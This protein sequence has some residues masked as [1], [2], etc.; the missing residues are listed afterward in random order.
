MIETLEAEGKDR[1]GFL[2]LFAEATGKW[3]RELKDATQTE[4]IAGRLL[5]LA[6]QY[7]EALHRAALLRQLGAAAAQKLEYPR[8][9]RQTEEAA[10]IFRENKELA[11]LIAC[12]N[13]LGKVYANLGDY[14]RAID[15]FDESLSLSSD[16]MDRTGEA[17]TLSALS[18]IYQRA[19]NAVKAGELARKSLAIAA[20]DGLERLE[21]IS[22]INLGNSYALAE[23]WNNAIAEW[24]QSIS[25]F[26]KLGETPYV[27]SALGNIGIAYQG[28]GKL[29]EAKEN[30]ERCLAV[31]QELNDIYDIARSLHN[32]GTVYLKM[33]DLQEA[34]KL[35]D[36]ALGMGEASQAKAIHVLIYQDMAE[37]LK[38]MGDYKGALE[39][40]EKF[41]E[42]Q[43]SL[44]HE[45]ANIKT[46][47]LQIRFEVEKK[48]KEN[49]IYRLRNIDLASANEKITLQKE[50][51]EQK[52]KDITDSILY[53]KR[54]Q[55][56]VLPSQERLRGWFGELFTLYAPKDIV[57]GDFYWAAEKDGKFLLAVADATGHGVPGAIMSMMGS[58]FLSEIVGEQG[59]TEPAP[60]LAMLRRKVINAMQ[61]TDAE[62]GDGMDIVLCAFDAAK[63]ELSAACAN[64]PLWL[65]RDENIT[66]VAPDKFP[67]GIFPGEPRRFTAHAV[68]LQ[69]GD[70]IYM[71]TDGFADQ[72]G[73]PRGKKFSYKQLRELLL[74]IHKLP[75]ETQKAELEKAF[76]EWKGKDEEQVDDVLVVGIRI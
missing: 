40:F 73:G 41:Y 4:A 44:F 64:N 8:A 6:E 28:L 21:A 69:P 67:V 50:V 33:G 72:F 17:N 12:N 60:A 34:K 71:F 62:T 38:Q 18:V 27:A 58:S 36:R 22:R 57:S 35:F 32:L 65:I 54:I 26:E 11:E 68:S 53:A 76:L 31:K 74:H 2:R 70:M 30:I 3:F 25:I 63:K 61:Q 7:G 45:D 29:E 39:V 13:Q 5:A 55:E 59:I 43:Q 14:S 66:V 1:E 37:I 51:I 15:L 19:G 20:E 48:E 49:E 9:I 75:M 10:A 52:N 56:A 47:A 23:E 42:L 16:I 24:T 46:Q